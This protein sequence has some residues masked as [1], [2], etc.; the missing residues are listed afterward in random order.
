MKVVATGRPTPGYQWYR[1]IA[2]DVT[3][4][5]PGAVQSTYVTPLLAT[6]TPYWVRVTNIAGSVA[7]NT[8]TV[9]V[10]R[11]PMIKRHPVS[12]TIAKGRRSTLRVEASGT[13][14]TY[15]WYVGTS[16]DQSRP[17][18]NATSSIY[19]TQVLKV[20]TRY[21]VKIKNPAGTAKSRT[22]TVVVR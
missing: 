14:L 5:I 22:V 20:T 18:K 8:A 6:T 10:Q 4:P 21:W 12:R 13:E 3:R 17:I 1:G 2:G 7:S 15:Q 9:T 11:A 19:R 16:G